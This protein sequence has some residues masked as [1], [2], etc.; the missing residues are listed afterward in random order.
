MPD[1]DVCFVI[2]PI[3]KSG[4]KT[5]QTFRDALDFVIRPALEGS[6]YE[7]QVIRADDIERPGSFIKDILE[8]LLNSFLVIADLTG[9]NPNV[10][11]EL[12][13]RHALSPRTIL[14]AQSMD[15]IPSDLREYRTIIYDTSAK[16]AADFKK[17]LEKFLAEIYDTP[18]RPDNPVLDRFGSIIEN[19]T[20]ELENQVIRLTEQLET[21]A[22]GEEPQEKPEGREHVINRVDR[23]L[24]VKQI[25][26]LYRGG[27][28]RRTQDDGSTI[29]YILTDNEGDFM[30]YSQDESNLM[31]LSKTESKPN[32][33]SLF[34]DMRV[35][36]GY[37]SQGPK[38]PLIFVIATNHDCSDILNQI[39]E[40]FLEQKRFLEPDQDLFTLQIW[41][42]GK[43]LEVERGLGLTLDRL[44]TL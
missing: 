35:L 43:L 24:K 3:G 25:H 13:V 9:Q 36:M 1:R 42:T 26:R 28:L 16:G 32:F 38:A 19:R 15:D 8:N 33:N 12:G 29:I 44:E 18:Q 31:Y 39:Q 11:Y 21:I 2:S 22:R 7:L 4:T 34:A 30:L 14:I 20:R 37:S 10:F 41:D 6:D 40:V 27:E 17:R 5:F 23:I